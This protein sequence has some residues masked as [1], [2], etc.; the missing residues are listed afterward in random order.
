MELM[1]DSANLE[2]IKKIKDLGLLAGLT[3]N[4]LIIKR[5]IEEMSYQGSFYD[6]AKQILDLTENKPCFF[7]TTGHSAKD[8][9]ERAKRIYSNL[10][11]YGNVYIKVPINPALNDSHDIFAGIETLSTLIKAKIPTLATAIVTPSQAYMAAQVRADYAVLMLRPYDNIIAEELGINLDQTGYF[12]DESARQA[13]QT[14]GIVEAS[15]YI[16]GIGTLKAASKM[17]ESRDLETK[18][19]LAGI[20]N[21]VQFDSAINEKGVSAITLPYMVF[22]HLLSHKGTRTF[23]EQTYE[24]APEIYKAFIEND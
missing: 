18:L 12:S 7:Q 24:G 2:E 5:G 1:L 17:F 10:H 13:Y 23:V 16:S 21:P 8:M 11:K 20:R 19:I 3:T 9:T 6:L 4:P 15:S 22:R 14:K